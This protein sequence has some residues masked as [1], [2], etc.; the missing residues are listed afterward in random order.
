MREDRSVLDFLDA[1]FIHVN[2]RLADHYGLTGIAGEAFQRVNLPTTL[3]RGGVL[4][5]ASIL[6]ITSNPTRTS[7][8]NRGKW[9]LEQILGAPPPPPPDNVPELEEA[10]A[11]GITMTLRQKLEEHRRNPECATCHDKMDP[12]GFALE[13]FDAIGAWRDRDGKSPIDS[14][15]VLPSG[16]QLDGPAS[17]KTIL[18]DDD[19]FTRTLIRRML[20]FALGRG[21]EYYDK[22]AIDRI[23]DDLVANGYRFSELAVGVATSRPFTMRNT[24]ALEP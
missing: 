2:Q 3:R 17:L 10:D 13:N 20:T 23:Y 8:V 18:K 16:E 21:L 9:I 1:D 4:T 7:S 24:T 6:T 5:Q 19:R 12:I 15:G 22:C 11:E 14:S